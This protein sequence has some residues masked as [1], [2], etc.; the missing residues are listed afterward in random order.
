MDTQRKDVDTLKETIERGRSYREE[1]TQRE[2]NYKF[3]VDRLLEAMRYDP[4]GD[5][6]SFWFYLN[7]QFYGGSSYILRVLEVQYGLGDSDEC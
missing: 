3:R 4:I 1:Q 5:D 7:D 2:E 6:S